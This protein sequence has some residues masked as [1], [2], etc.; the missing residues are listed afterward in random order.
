[1]DLSS[2]LFKLAKAK[3][4][5]AQEGASSCLLKPIEVLCNGICDGRLAGASFTGQPEDRRAVRRVGPCDYNLS[6]FGAWFAGHYH[7]G[8]QVS[9]VDRLPSPNTIKLH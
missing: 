9:I 3:K 4:A 7:T 8:P 1:M 6:V 5:A 2:C